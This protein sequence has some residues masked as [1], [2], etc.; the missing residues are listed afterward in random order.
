MQSLPPEKIE[1]V[2]YDGEFYENTYLKKS[3]FDQ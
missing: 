1:F 2:A 3:Y